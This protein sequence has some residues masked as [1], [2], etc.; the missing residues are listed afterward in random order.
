MTRPNIHQIVAALIRSGDEVLLVREQ[1]PNDPAAVWALPG[2]IV[3][4][5][6]LFTE[7][8]IREVRE[9]TGLEVRT[10][11]QLVYIAQ[12]HN[13]TGQLWSEG[14]VPGTGGQA[15]TFV[16]Q[17]DGWGGT[18]RPSDPD[19]FVS[20]ARFWPMAEAISKLQELPLRVM[21]EPIVAYLCG[22][23]ERGAVWLYRRQADGSD[24]LIARVG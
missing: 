23:V 10:P 20:E 8:L 24:E 19:G 6:E 5:G 9:E 7:A 22:E 3:E 16:F 4:A 17:V 15:V 2:G 12:L 11:G 18:V 14:E 1:G 21:R 13:P